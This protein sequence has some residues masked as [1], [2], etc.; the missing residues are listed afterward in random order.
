L[1]SSSS[2]MCSNTDIDAD[3]AS[4][5]AT[6]TKPI[7]PTKSSKIRSKHTQRSPDE[8]YCICAQKASGT[9]IACD[10]EVSTSLFDLNFS[11]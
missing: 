6:S 11:D 9:M 8:L 7:K 5:K 10:N 3:K 4:K 2:P 1:T